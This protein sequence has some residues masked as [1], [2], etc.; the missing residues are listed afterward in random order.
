[1]ITAPNPGPKTLGGTNC[2]LVGTTSLI[3]V[4]PGPNMPGYLAELARYVNS[5]G[6]IEA[7]WLTHGHP[8]HASGAP[9]M[10]QL[11]GVAVFASRPG[12]FAMALKPGDAIRLGDFTLSVVSA[13]GHSIDHL[14]FFLEPRRILFSGDAILGSGS[15]LI[16]LPEGNMVDY[17]ATLNR[18]HSLEPAL[19]APGHG[20]LVKDPRAKIDEY[21][22]H[23]LS[24]EVELLLALA[25]GPL[26][27]PELVA[28]VYEDME[29][30]VHRLAELSV[31]AQLAKLS[32]EDRVTRHGERFAI[33][34]EVGELDRTS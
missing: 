27:I 18:L 8:D 34:S 7:I 25:D 17:M 11:L 24:R 32:H 14:C 1:M 28:K 23:R 6:K 22:A 13:P 2:Y 30:E 3:L 5:V 19:I 9:T 15:T 29:P 20:P 4:D 33:A 31:G 10:A 21:I 12:D 16:A 26:T